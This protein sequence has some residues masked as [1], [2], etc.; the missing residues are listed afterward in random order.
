MTK[1]MTLKQH[2]FVCE[3]HTDKFN[4]LPYDIS[5]FISSKVVLV[6]SEEAQK[7]LLGFECFGIERQ[8]W[9]Y[10]KTTGFFV[11]FQTLLVDISRN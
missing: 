4:Y 7:K 3:I 2:V 10:L 6:I 9:V 8:T 5:I 1:G 11:E